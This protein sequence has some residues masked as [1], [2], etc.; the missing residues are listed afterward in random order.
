MSFA[1]TADT[2]RFEWKGGGN[3]WLCRETDRGLARP[4]QAGLRRN[5]VERTSHG[6]VVHDSHGKSNTQ[7]L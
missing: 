2:G 3:N 6:V 5:V 4:H 7:H 1:V